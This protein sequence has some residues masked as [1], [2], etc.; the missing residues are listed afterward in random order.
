MRSIIYSNFDKKKINN[1]PR[2]IFPGKIQVIETADAASVAV[3][4]L[5]QKKILGI[6]TETRPSFKKGRSHK[7]ALLQVSTHKECFLFRL[8][9]IGMTNSIISLLEDITI[10]KV[11]ISLHDDFHMLH[12]RISFNPGYFIDLQDCVK[13]IGINDLSLQKIYANIFGKKIVKREQ[14]TNWENI[15]LTDK[16]KQ[17]AAI[18][19]W[20]CINLYE[21]IKELKQTGDYN[22]I[23]NDIR[24]SDL[25]KEKLEDKS[26]INY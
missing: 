25:Q 15:E 22:L 10:P 5:L 24:C 6:D 3:N 17:Y 13:D 1:L 2:V 20:A 9:I 12:K 7:V 16:Q 14:L 11:G 26:R 21:R 8:N 19:A 18:D 23:K 4:Y